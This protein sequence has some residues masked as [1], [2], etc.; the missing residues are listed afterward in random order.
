MA[1][2]ESTTA[3]GLQNFRSLYLTLICLQIIASGLFSKGSVVLSAVDKNFNNIDELTS[4]LRASMLLPGVA[5]APVQLKGDQILGANLRKANW[6]DYIGREKIET[7]GSEPLLDAQL[8]EPIPYRSALNEN[9]SHVLVFRTRAD[10][11]KVTK[12]ISV[13]EKMMLKRYFRK[14]LKLPDV[15]DW[16]LKQVL[17]FESFG[18]LHFMH[19]LI[20][21][22]GNIF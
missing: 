1:T 15:C 6:T 17:L 22:Q 20:E 3:Q 9:C 21:T 4:C 8:F 10:G 5:G 7:F 14:K 12:R 13:V 2:A 16:M 19:I 18:T 11:I